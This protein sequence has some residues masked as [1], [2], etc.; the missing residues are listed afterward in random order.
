MD[1][2]TEMQ[3][4]KGMKDMPNQQYID[5]E[6]GN[7]LNLTRR[8]PFGFIYLSLEKGT[9]PPN[10]AGSCWTDWDQAKIAAMGYVRER[11]D[12]VAEIREKTAFKRPLK[13]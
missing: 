8:D 2:F 7:K 1:D 3:I 6:N 12:T 10:L 13:D 9:L 11:Q 5:L 4:Q